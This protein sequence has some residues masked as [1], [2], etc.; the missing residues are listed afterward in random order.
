M[1][2]STYTFSEVPF[3]FSEVIQYDFAKGGN[4]GARP[5]KNQYEIYG[6]IYLLTEREWQDYRRA[7]LEFKKRIKTKTAEE[8]VEII[9]DNQPKY[10]HLRE[11]ILSPVYEVNR[12]EIPLLPDLSL[13]NDIEA[14]AYSKLLEVRRNIEQL[15]FDNRAKQSELLRK[16]KREQDDLIALFLLL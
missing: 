6:R 8:L 1:M 7:K 3:C 2:F 5:R 4:P 13:A 15:E 16:K 12:L 9:V 11:I 10:K 14:A